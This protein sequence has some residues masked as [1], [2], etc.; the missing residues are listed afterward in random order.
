MNS[1]F[2]RDSG[3]ALAVSPHSQVDN[4]DANL[5]QGLTSSLVQLFFAWRVWVLTSNIWAL[6]VIVTFS[7]ANFS[8]G[9]YLG[10]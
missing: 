4:H 7:L 3:A 1:A 5:M 2:L 8:K 10:P 9:Q 6:G